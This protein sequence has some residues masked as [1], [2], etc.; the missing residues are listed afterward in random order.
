MPA[1]TRPS[2]I[3]GVADDSLDAGAGE[4]LSLHSRL[5]G[6][7][8]VRSTPDAG[9]QP[10]GVLAHYD[11][12]EVAGRFAGQRRRHPR[13]QPRRPGADILVESLADGQPQPSQ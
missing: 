8:A 12:V 10:F 7:T 9:I 2:Q 13:Q 4:Y 11:D 3:E 6:K 1:G 5:A